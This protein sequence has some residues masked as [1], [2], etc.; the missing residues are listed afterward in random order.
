MEE[1]QKQNDAFVSFLSNPNATVKDY[2][3]NGI[4]AENT[5]LL[6]LEEYK[7]TPL[8]KK[9]FSDENGV[10]NQDLFEKAYTVAAEKYFELGDEEGFQNF[11]EYSP[12]SRYSP[13]GSKMFV[14]D[15]SAEVGNNPTARSKGLTGLHSLGK[16]YLTEEELAQQGKIWDSE[17]KKWLPQTAESRN[18]FKKAFGKTLVY[19]KY[20]TSGYQANPITGEMGLHHEGEWMT[21]EN[22]SYFTMTVNKDELG[23]K[24][25]VAFEDILTKENSWLNKIDF[26]DSDG[27]EKSIVGVTAKTLVHALPYLIPQVRGVMG[28]VA[29]TVNLV[30]VMPT[31][32]KALEGIITGDERTSATKGATSVENWFKKFDNSFSKHG[33]EH[34]FSYESMMSQL[35]DVFG[36]LY[37]QRAAYDLAKR[38]LKYDPSKFKNIAEYEAAIKKLTKTG[39]AMSIGYMALTSTANI[40][41]EALNAGYDR[42]TAGL[43]AIASAL[44]S[45]GIMNYNETARGIGTWFTKA[46]TGEENL[47]YPVLSVAR[48]NFERARKIVNDNLKPN[49]TQVKAFLGDF[50]A[51]VKYNAQGIFS[52]TGESIWRGLLNE[53]AEEVSEEVIQDAVKGIVDTLSYL[54]FTE[55]K[56]SFGGWDNVFSKEGAMRYLQTAVAGGLG[57]GLFALQQFKI[58]PWM[59]RMFKDPNYKTELQKKDEMDLVDISLNG[60][61]EEYIKELKNIGK[62][63][64]T[65]RGVTSLVKD[66]GT[67]IDLKANGQ[68]NQAD[69]VISDLI[70]QARALD[71][72]IKRFAGFNNIKT[73]PLT[74]REQILKNFGEKIRESKASEYLEKKFEDRMKQVVTDFTNLKAKELAIKNAT[75]D[76][77]ITDL[78][79]QEKEAKE[80]FESSLKEVRGFFNGETIVDSMLEISLLGDGDIMSALKGMTEEEFYNYYFMSDSLPTPYNKLTEEEKAKVTEAF[81][82]YK[83]SAAAD[84]D[85]LVREIPKLSKLYI[86]MLK[87]FGDDLNNLKNLNH[88]G[89]YLKN[90]GNFTEFVK[91]NST[92]ET[93]SPEALLTSEE[94]NNPMWRSIY[95]KKRDA[96]LLGKITDRIKANPISFNLQALQGFDLA[97]KL[98]SSGAINLDGYNE[99]QSKL[100]KDWINYIAIK[101]GMLTITQDYAQSIINFINQALANPEANPFALKIKEE[102]T[103]DLSPIEFSSDKFTNDIQAVNIHSIFDLISDGKT[104]NIEITSEIAEQIRSYTIARLYNMF[105]SSGIK[106]KDGKDLIENLQLVVLSGLRFGANTNL[107]SILKPIFDFSDLTPDLEAAIK[108]IC[109]EITDFTS[110]A[111]I[112]SEDLPLNNILQKISS[113]I[114]FKDFDLLEQLDE[115]QDQWRKSNF[116]GDQIGL[117]NEQREQLKKFKRQISIVN[118][119]AEGARSMGQSKGINEIQREFLTA[120]KNKK[121]ID[122]YPILDNIDYDLT[123]KYIG[124]ISYTIDRLLDLDSELNQSKEVQAEEQRNQFIAGYT[125]FLNLIKGKAFQVEI[126]DD[127]GLQTKENIVLINDSTI[128]ERSL[129]SIALIETE[130]ANVLRQLRT[131]FKND[132]SYI[133]AIVKMVHSNPEFNWTDFFGTSKPVWESFQFTASGAIHYVSGRAIVNRLIQ[134]AYSHPREEYTFLNKIY[135]ANSDISPKI[136]QTQALLSIK[137]ALNHKDKI[138]ILN[139]V[140]N[141]LKKGDASLIDKQL[142]DN[143]TVLLG[144]GG[145]GKT[146]LATLVATSENPDKILMS[147]LNEAKVNDL[148]Q[149]KYEGDTLYNLIPQLQNLNDTFLSKLNEVTTKIIKTTGNFTEKLEEIKKISGVTVDGNNVI[150]ENAGL[151]F[152]LKYINV[153]TP[154]TIKIDLITD[155]DYS[156]IKDKV[157]IVDECTLL[158]PVIWKALSNSGATVIALGDPFQNSWK[159]EVDSYNI[160]NY[161]VNTAGFLKGAWRAD[162]T[163]ILDFNTTFYKTL[164][165]GGIW[166]NDTEIIVDSTKLNTLLQNIKDTVIAT[167]SQTVDSFRGVK[168]VDDIKD[169]IATISNLNGT[170]AIIT[171]LSKDQI[172]KEFGKLDG[173]EI[174]SLDTVQ[175]KEYDYTIVYELNGTQSTSGIK[176]VFTATTRAKKGQIIHKN[177]FINS[178]LNINSKE[179]IVKELIG[180]RRGEISIKRADEINQIANWPELKEPV[181]ILSTIDDKGDRKDEEQ[182]ETPPNSQTWISAGFISPIGIETWFFRLGVSKDFIEKNKNE[183]LTIEE[184]KDKFDKSEK[185]SKKSDLYHYIMYLQETNSGSTKNFLKWNDLVNE[186]RSFRQTLFKKEL[187]DKSYRIFI[188]KDSEDK[189]QW[190]ADKLNDN[191]QKPEYRIGIAYKISKNIYHFTLGGISSSGIETISSKEKLNIKENQIIYFKQNKDKEQKDAYNKLLQNIGACQ[192]FR[193]IVDQNK[194]PFRQYTSPRWLKVDTKL[195]SNKPYMIKNMMKLE[196][197]LENGWQIVTNSGLDLNTEDGFLKGKQIYNLKELTANIGWMHK[198]TNVVIQYDNDQSTR[199]II[200]LFSYADNIVEYFKKEIENK[201]TYAF[202]EDKGTNSGKLRKVEHTHLLKGLA[203]INGINAEIDFSDN[204]QIEKLSNEIKGNYEDLE[205]KKQ[206]DNLVTSLKQYNKKNKENIEWNLVITRSG[207]VDKIAKIPEELDKEGYKYMIHTSNSYESGQPYYIEYII[208]TPKFMIDFNELEVKDFDTIVTGN[209][210]NTDKTNPEVI[211]QNYKN[212]VINIIK[213]YLDY[214]GYQSTDIN[215][216]IDNKVKSDID[217]ETIKNKEDA[218]TLLKTYFI[219]PSKIS[220]D[221]VPPSPTKSV[222]VNLSILNIEDIQKQIPSPFGDKLFNITC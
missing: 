1:K 76:V 84:V 96:I 191:E 61:I 87:Y 213:A 203:Y 218:L 149:D 118:I 215:W 181:T 133:E 44:A 169:D 210:G 120:Y 12:T 129:A 83:T 164:L 41:G 119:I 123:S 166:D 205:L 179:G 46:V 183:N 102:G 200:P 60:Q 140:I 6:S 2:L 110:K 143:I 148:K 150:V 192:Q 95:V 81:D 67:K 51:D 20:D 144:A 70:D 175:G 28:A 198:Y 195:E 11:L 153:D 78:K 90:F 45:F 50:W 202:S 113:I 139:K 219:T 197:L 62:I 117:T 216:V 74:L 130:I 180:E 199:F 10:F 208:E 186:Y 72:W 137:F 207:F 212:E 8:V 177:S 48:K 56:G 13:I 104:G 66:D 25:V 15:F 54:G 142:L 107:F 145:S 171:D 184:W 105:T 82:Q 24:Q 128:I 23:N 63:M 106:S 152:T 157:L 3:Q 30:S 37:Q 91:D 124:S 53:A 134:L 116:A 97:S 57:G 159:Y 86:N 161:E 7:E 5:Q 190:A 75:A 73:L 16:Q 77:D 160:E 17:N 131:K 58:E 201:S 196:A 126:P 29:A 59:N 158:S 92:I 85:G 155:L 132:E 214:S 112:I 172:E 115:L 47:R 108:D 9:K 206:I 68:T 178:I 193:N 221:G 93:L 79:N 69:M 101:D 163:A 65:K 26:F 43:A 42:R 21:D 156:K 165:N 125:D 64:N 114:G 173:W 127:E 18:I 136:D 4:T 111:T 217:F 89:T 168:L 176:K 100:I 98:E 22:G 220:K 185:V 167:Y 32:Y 121:D 33:R 39:Q 35:G 122:K 80:A 36:Q 55:K 40:Y 222:K 194:G 182:P 154:P 162:N 146:L 204:D 31:F 88:K 147:A 138:N 151:K 187:D 34:F 38:V 135:S 94:L 141:E 109:S 71:T 14:T 27:Y 52:Q 170:K 211:A 209:G 103:E 188:T 19:A 99:T 49:S 189:Y 174:V